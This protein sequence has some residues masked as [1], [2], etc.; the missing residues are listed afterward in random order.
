MKR[1]SIYNLGGSSGSS[2]SSGPSFPDILKFN[3]ATDQWEKT[4]EMNIPRCNHAVAALP[5][6]EV[7][8]FC[9]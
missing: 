4:G 3:P 8:P 6:K 9:S 5:L 1:N 2:G 7:E